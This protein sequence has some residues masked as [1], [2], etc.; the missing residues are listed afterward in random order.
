MRIVCP[1]IGPALVLA[2]APALGAELFCSPVLPRE[3][4]PFKI[5]YRSG[6]PAEDGAAFTVRDSDGGI[7]EQ[8]T[9]PLVRRPD[10][11]T[12]ELDLTVPHN[13]LLAAEVVAGHLKLR[14]VVPVISAKRE[15]NI[16]YYGMDEQLLRRGLVHWV[17]LVTTCGGEA[18]ADLTARGAK[19]LG[20]RLGSNVLY[21]RE[22]ELEA[23]G[24][25]LTPE[26]ARE[27]GR[28]MYTGDAAEAVAKGYAGFGLDEF[29]G[30]AASATLDGTKAFVRGMIEAR[31][32]L[33]PG[34]I[35]AAWHGGPLDSELIGLYKQAVEFLLPEAYLLDIVPAQLG[36]ERIDRDLE[37]R[38]TNARSND[39]FTAPY[40][41]RCKVIPSVDLTDTIPVDEYE[42]FFRMLRRDFPEVRGIAFFNVLSKER[43]ETYRVID[44]LCLDYFIKPVLTFQPDS[45]SFDRF[46]DKSVIAR[47]SNIGAMDS[48]PATVRLLVDDREV[49]RATVQ[50][51][52]AGFSRVDNRADARFDWRPPATGTYRLRVEIAN[53]G[54]GTVLDP[55]AEVSMYLR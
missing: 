36:T 48:G 40:G 32:T 43:Y 20:W 52:P 26:L 42:G 31:D 3:S 11:L 6:T 22:K 17:T 38:L 54:D 33:P 25:A 34:F 29:G 49:G 27:I 24:R 9:V 37:G 1:L 55:A 28:R 4:E 23:E 8:R 19:G 50:S 12:A 45:I 51:V 7:L 41:A 14:T 10:G 44:E 16:I 30:Y 47:L 15:V 53:A 5:V 39:L 18:L 2:A 21:D 46:G 35:L 13:G